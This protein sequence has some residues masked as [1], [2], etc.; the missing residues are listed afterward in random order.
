MIPLLIWDK[1]EKRLEHQYS[2]QIPNVFLWNVCQAI[3]HGASKLAQNI[4]N[5]DPICV[6]YRDGNESHMHLFMECPTFTLSWVISFKF[7]PLSHAPNFETIF[8]GIIGF[9]IT[10]A[11]LDYKKQ[12]Q[13]LGSIQPFSTSYNRLLVDLA[14]VKL[15]FK[16]QEKKLRWND[17]P[18]WKLPPAGFAKLD[19]DG[20]RKG[21]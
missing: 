15:A 2:V 3:L 5:F 4:V 6:K 12:G 16:G 11:N 17:H 9:I 20:C 19:M 14:V 18:T 21:P 13:P 10:I 8:N 7:I 1:R